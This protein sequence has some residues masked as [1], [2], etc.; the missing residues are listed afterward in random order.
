MIK[1]GD[2]AEFGEN[3][4]GA[5]HIKAPQADQGL[6]HWRQRP[7]RSS[8]SNL[9]VQAGYT[10]RRLI[11]GINIFLKD[12][13]LHRMIE[14]LVREPSL[15]RLRPPALARINTGVTDEE[16]AE[17]LPGFGLKGDHIL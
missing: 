13:L 2:V 5:E 15:V 9:L 11:A 7:G 6:H 1:T 3:G 10:T 16:G 12:Q 4:D 14:G 17:P 8:R